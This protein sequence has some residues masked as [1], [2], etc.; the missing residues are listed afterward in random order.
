MVNFMKGIPVDSR[1]FKKL[2][3]DL[4]IGCINLLLHMKIC[5][6]SSERFLIEHLSG[7]MSNE[8]TCNEP[9]K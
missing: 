1:I 9:A 3:N 2:Y 8:I 5:W 4:D 6:Q 7:R